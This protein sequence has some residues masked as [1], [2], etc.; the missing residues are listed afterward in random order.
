LLFDADL[1]KKTKRRN[2]RCIRDVWEVTPKD[3]DTWVKINPSTSPFWFNRTSI[4]MLP[5]QESAGNH[6]TT[7][8]LRSATPQSV[9]HEQV[10]VEVRKR[11]QKY[12]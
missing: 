6:T 5:H 12:N 9:V 11:L 8:R 2:K 7:K 10:H 1:E 3:R 4:D